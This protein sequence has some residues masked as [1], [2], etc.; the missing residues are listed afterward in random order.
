MRAIVIRAA[1]LGCALGLMGCVTP[2]MQE[3]AARVRILEPRPLVDLPDSAKGMKL[4]IDT[5]VGDSFTIA[6]RD[7]ITAVPVEGWHSSLQNG[8]T[9]GPGRFFKGN[10]AEPD[11]LKLT[12]LNAELDY[13][14]TAVFTQG[15]NVVGAAAVQARLR[16][17]A[18]LVDS[19][20]EVLARDQ[21][22]VFSTSQWTGPGGSSTTASE[23][24]AAMYQNISKQIV[25][26]LD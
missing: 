23:A 3:D 9:N 20:G 16:Y 10:P 22:E 2:A 12:I 8:F 11:A 7:G 1:L 25:A 15:V 13:V 26:A 24:I 5:T 19:R 17:V 4:E 18:R 21:G 6:Q 14:P